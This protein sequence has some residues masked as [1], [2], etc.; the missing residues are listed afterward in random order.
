VNKFG[1]GTPDILFS[2]EALNHAASLG[3]SK[4]LAWYKE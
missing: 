4:K 1:T 3:Y 2:S